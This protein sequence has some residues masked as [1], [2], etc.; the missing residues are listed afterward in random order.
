MVFNIFKHFFEFSIC[1]HTHIR[2]YMIMCIVVA[3]AFCLFFFFF[4]C[5]FLLLFFVLFCFV[6]VILREKSQVFF[7]YSLLSASRV[8]KISCW[9]ELLFIVLDIYIYIYIYIYICVCVCVCVCVSIQNYSNLILFG[10]IF[11]SSQIMSVF[12][13]VKRTRRT[14]RKNILQSALF[15]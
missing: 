10:I 12:M 1:K 15:R 6:E 14:N 3:V 4:C 13:S 2:L 5:F 8:P 9:S 11:F 7:L